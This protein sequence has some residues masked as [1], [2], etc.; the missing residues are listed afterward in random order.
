MSDQKYTDEDFVYINPSRR[1]VLGKVE[2]LPNGNPKKMEKTFAEEDKDE[3]GGKGRK[4]RKR[5][6]QYFPWG[7]YRTMKKLFR[8]EGKEK[9]IENYRPIDEAMKLAINETYWD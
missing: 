8:V 4:L 7:S 5:K 2:W 3:E 6:K 1:E 9:E